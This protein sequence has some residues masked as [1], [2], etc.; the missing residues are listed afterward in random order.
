ME[1]NEIKIDDPGLVIIGDFLPQAPTSFGKI[2]LGYYG[3]T[4]PVNIGQVVIGQYVSIVWNP[5][6]IIK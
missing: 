2:Q 3:V 5:N 1:K 4:P 6:I